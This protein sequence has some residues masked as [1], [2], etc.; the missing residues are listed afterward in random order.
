[1]CWRPAPRSSACL[2]IVNEDPA[3]WDDSSCTK[4]RRVSVG[5]IENEPLGVLEI[6][7]AQT[8]SDGQ[9]LMGGSAS[10]LRPLVRF[11]ISLL[12]KDVVEVAGSGSGSQSCRAEDGD[13]SGHSHH[14]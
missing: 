2:S 10:M 4:V 13:E 14:G 9:R 12:V 1:M 11:A 5:N 8:D 6:P 7:L 3:R